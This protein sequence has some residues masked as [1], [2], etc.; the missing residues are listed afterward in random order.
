MTTTTLD[1]ADDDRERARLVPWLC[2]QDGAVR[3]EELVL[4]LDAVAETGG[5]GG[6]WDAVMSWAGANRDDLVRHLTRD[7]DHY[8]GTRG[9]YLD[10]RRERS[11]KRRG[12]S[13]KR[14]LRR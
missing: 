10:A 7:A 11:P 2:S 9:L 14:Q 4:A 3:R 5:V 6:T 12:K 1:A 8:F 13:R